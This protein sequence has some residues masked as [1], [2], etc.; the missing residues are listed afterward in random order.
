MSLADRMRADF[1]VF[2]WALWRELGLPN[3]TPVQYEMADYLQHGPRRRVVCAFRGVGKS[4]ITAA[5]V[6]WCLWV[7]PEERVL[8]LSASKDRSDAFTVF[9]KRLIAEVEWLHHLAPD[10]D[11]GQRDSNIA[12]D[13]GPAS[14]AQAPSVKSVGVYG[15]MTGSRATKIVF[16]DAEVP[17][18][19]ETATQREKLLRRVLEGGAA[20][21]APGGE[22]V[23]LGT[24]QTE[25]SLYNHL[26]QHGYEV[27]IWPARVPADAGVY[28]GKLAPSIQKMVD[29]GVTAGTPTDPLRF[30][31]TEL[32]EREIE[33]GAAGFA[34]Q[35][36]LDT[37]L[38]DV[39]R[40]PLK[41]ADF[42]VMNVDTSVAPTRVV[43][44]S[45][46]EQVIEDLA[47]PGMPGDRWHRPMFRADQFAP[48][49]LTIMYIDPSGR[50]RDET[51]YAVA[52]GL[53]GMIYIP[54]WSGV[55]DGYSQETLAHLATLA[56]DHKVQRIVVE[57]NFG[58]GMW[59]E[60]FKPVLFRIHKDGCAIEGK[61]VGIMQKEHRILDTL[62]PA[63]GAHRLVIDTELIKADLRP[64][65]KGGPDAVLKTNL[66]QLTRLTRDRGCLKFDDRVD[67]L[68]GAVKEHMTLLGRDANDAE[69]KH[70]EEL[71][72]KEL[73]EW[74]DRVMPGRHRPAT[75]ND[76][77]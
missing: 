9:V 30:N 70:K 42:I 64:K 72:D 7:N 45:A 67:A 66:Y 1:K 2:L 33:Y 51:A 23:Y 61:K 50:G 25:D 58:D 53:H 32:A 19:S 60:L 56:R 13:V 17:N 55:Q 39:D 10:S 63:L 4:W 38:A 57:D 8:V 14:P 34:L 71:L 73:S 5:Y 16:D 48:Y 40:Y 59:V 24:P 35:F 54:V 44:G 76:V 52:K 20:V 26:P 43:W 74:F 47:N 77:L 31:I 75:W 15:Q 62:G 28:G 29:E 11:A 12:F 22:V 41:C 68:A 6:L 69:R 27:R 65:V 21:L 18:N 49:E 46:P 3:P 36:M 37:T